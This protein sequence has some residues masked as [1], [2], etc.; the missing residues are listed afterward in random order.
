MKF[1]LKNVSK[2]YNKLTA[3]EVTALK[4]IDMKIS[5]DD[6]ISIMGVS[7]SGK[8]TLLNII[9][10]LDVPTEGEYY[11]DDVNIKKL[12]ANKIRNEIIGFVLQNFG[13]LPNKSVY[14][15]VAY[16]LLLGKKVKYRDIEAKVDRALN[17]VEM[18]S[19]R[20]RLVSQL[21][22]GQRQRIAIARAIVGDPA[23]ILADEPTAALDSG[24]AKEIMTL[25]N[26]L[27]EQGTAIIIVTHDPAVAGICHKQLY[28]SD[29]NLREAA[30]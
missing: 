6:F 9:G 11:I 27:N 5:G 24:T 30:V 17:R 19:F 3:S 8:S 2:I 13:L 21:S 29:G 18:V 12:D 16:P 1:E 4:N 25:F 28:I 26:E 14:E 22:G 7:G 23:L 15:N 10:C 20:N